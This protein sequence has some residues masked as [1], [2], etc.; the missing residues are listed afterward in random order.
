MGA[1]DSKTYN[2]TLP[3]P[4]GVR[5]LSDTNAKIVVNFGDEK[6]RTIENVQIGAPKNLASGLT[7]NAKGEE[8]QSVTVVVKGVQSVI[9]SISA[10]DISAYVDL[11]GY[12]A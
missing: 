3:K 5:Y 7:A 9:D 11:S 4:S 2:V 8:N 12:N 6:Q 10:D 1:N